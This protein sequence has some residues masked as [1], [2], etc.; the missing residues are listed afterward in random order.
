[1]N[2]AKGKIHKGVEEGEK[3]GGRGTEKLKWP[4]LSTVIVSGL[5]ERDRG[6]R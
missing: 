6:E 1:M 5:G 2:S 4:T 3:L